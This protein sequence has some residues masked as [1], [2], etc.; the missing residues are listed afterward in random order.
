MATPTANTDAATKLYV[1][2]NGGLS[3]AT[4]DTYYYSFANTNLPTT[5]LNLNS[6][7]IINLA[8]ATLATDALNR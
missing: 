6:N 8:D 3:K 2:S 5:S 4:A 7:K 1:D